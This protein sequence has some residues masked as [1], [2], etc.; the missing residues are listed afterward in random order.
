M[1]I[2]GEK[3]PEDARLTPRCTYLIDDLCR[4][5]V[6][7]FQGVF[8]VT[9]ALLHYVATSMDGGGEGGG[10]GGELGLWLKHPPQFVVSH[11]YNAHR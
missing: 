7:I 9:P 6:G 2:T 4:Y 10:G 1:G 11:L 8:A 5:L 3:C